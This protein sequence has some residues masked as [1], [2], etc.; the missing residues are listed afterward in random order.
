MKAELIVLV[1][2]LAA[3][4]SPMP[5]RPAEPM[6]DG[7]PAIAPAGWRDLCEREPETPRC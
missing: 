2:L 6:P 4:C 5:P 3:A 7:G 1:A